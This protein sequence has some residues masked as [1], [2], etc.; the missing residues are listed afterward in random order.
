M[1]TPKGIAV[2]AACINGELD[3]SYI[4]VPFPLYFAWCAFPDVIKLYDAE[5]LGLYLLGSHARRALWIYSPRH[6]DSLLEQHPLAGLV[7]QP[8]SDGDRI[9]GKR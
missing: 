5:I 4:T 3:L 9:I 2:A 6:T 8:F 1:V 7:S